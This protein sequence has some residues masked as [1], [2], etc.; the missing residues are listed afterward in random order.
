MKR[1]RIA[2]AYAAASLT[3]VVA[4]LT[5]FVLIGAFTHGVAAIGLRIDPVFSGGDAAYTVARPGYRIVVNHP[6]V[7]QAPL[8]GVPAFVQLAW[9]PAS[10][11]PARVSDEVDV[12]GDGRPDLI[13]AFAVPRD[14]ATPLTADV[15]PTGPVVVPTGVVHRDSLALLI[16][17]VGDRVVL[18][19]PVSVM[20]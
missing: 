7:P 17:R 4:I 15:R 13:V 1:S 10:A 19:V 5:P 18:R 8:S 2:L 6:V 3:I 12:N 14:V 9:E 16:A 11:L 20:P